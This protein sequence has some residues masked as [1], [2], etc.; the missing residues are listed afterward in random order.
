MVI[1]AVLGGIAGSQVG[2]GSSTNVLIGAVLGGIAGGAIGQRHDEYRE[3]LRREE[4]QRQF[5]YE[6]EME[7]Q[8]R[9]EREIEALEEQRIRDALAR[10]ATDEDVALAEAQAARIQRQ[11]D[12]KKAEFEASQERARRIQEARER[13]EQAKRELDELEARERGEPVNG[14]TGAS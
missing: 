4:A 3:A 13:I 11:L 2:D 1:G 5:E 10:Q 6:Q 14:G 12:E 7:R 8:A 9:L